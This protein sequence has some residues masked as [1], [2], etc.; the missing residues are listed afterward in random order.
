MIKVQRKE[1]MKIF[2]LRI[3]NFPKL[4]PQY[5]SIKNLKSVLFYA[6]T[7]K[8][9]AL[10]IILFLYSFEYDACI[11]TSEPKPIAQYD[12]QA[13]LLRLIEC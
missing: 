8:I 11:M 2:G 5:R 3:S 7:F 12:I 4:P 6:K 9:N 13:A 1:T 10:E